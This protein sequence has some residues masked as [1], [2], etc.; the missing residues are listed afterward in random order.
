MKYSTKDALKA[1]FLRYPKMTPQDTVK[2]IFQSEFGPGH[3]IADKNYACNRLKAELASTVRDENIPTVEFIGGDAC[4]FNLASLPAELSPE[5]LT[6]IFIMSAE[7]FSGSE[8]AFESK[9]HEVYSLIDEK[10]APFSRCEYSEFLKKYF[11]AG[12]GA[13]HHSSDYNALYRPAYR[14]MH[15]S[16]A[17]LLPLLAEI[18]MRI[19]ANECFNV[20]LEGHCGADNSALAA[21]LSRIYGCGTIH[22]NDFIIDAT[23]F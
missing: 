5:T 8:H 12:K 21:I 22:A 1:H 14:V 20:S 23:D 11:E 3:L 17:S 4:R 10:Q 13:L 9:L 19:S 7:M 15:V 18:D 2:L 6:Q 16:F